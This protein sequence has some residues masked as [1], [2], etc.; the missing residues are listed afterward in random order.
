MMTKSDLYEAVIGQMERL[1]EHEL[2]AH[3]EELKKLRE[4]NAYLIKQCTSYQ[5]SLAKR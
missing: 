2:K 4:E 5:E 3:K 1:H